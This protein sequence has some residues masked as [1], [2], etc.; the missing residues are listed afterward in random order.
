ML[1]KFERLSAEGVDT[2]TERIWGATICLV[3]FTVYGLIEIEGLGTGVYDQRCRCQESAKPQERWAGFDFN[4]YLELCRCCGIEPLKSGSRWSP[5][6]CRECRD[7]VVS[8]NR[9]HGRWI[10]PI[11][12]HSMMHGDLLGG[13]EAAIKEHAE[14]FVLR[15]RGLFAAIDHLD[16]WTSTRVK[17]NLETLSC[18]AGQEVDL[19]YYLSAAR[20]RPLN[21]QPAFYGLRDHFIRSADPKG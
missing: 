11:G 16:K 19:G 17:E 12:R 4:T 2:V 15:V 10:I 9:R 3:C 7:C 1:L 5:Y 14:H 21:K 13:D 8:F 6:F 20:R 18:A